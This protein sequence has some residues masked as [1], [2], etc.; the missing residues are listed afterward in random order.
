MTEA[1]DRLRSTD[2]TEDHAPSVSD[3]GSGRQ[4]A[5]T[6]GLV[7]IPLVITAVA[8]AFRHWYPTGDLAQA[9]MRLQSFPANPPLVGAAGR[10]VS[11]AGVQGNHPGP[12]FFWAAYPIYLLL[13][14][15]AWASEASVAALNVA[16]VGVGLWLVRRVAGPAMMLSMAL[17]FAVLLG[18]YGLDAGT[19]LWNPWMALWPFTVLVLATW[20]ALAGHRTLPLAVAA[21]TWAVQAHA[22]YAVVAP[23]LVAFAIVGVAAQLGWARRQGSPGLEP[24]GATGLGRL[25]PGRFGVGL[26]SGAGR[27]LVMWAPPLVDEFTNEPGNLTILWQHF[28]SPDEAVL[29]LREAARITLRLLDPFGQWITGGQFIEGSLIAG[30]GLLIAWAA[31]IVLVCRRGWWDIARLDAAVGVAV[32]VSALSISRAFGVVVLYLFRWVLGLTAL[33]IVAT[34]WPVV[35]ELWARYATADDRLRWSW[36]ADPAELAK[37]VTVGGVVVLV[38]LAGVNTARMVTADIPYE[39]SWSQMAELIDPIVGDLDPDLRYDV[40]WEDPLNLGGLGFGTI[41]ELEHRG[42][43]VGG[44]PQFSAAIEPHR[45]F[46]PGEADAELWVVTGSRTEAWRATPGVTEL[47]AFD[48]RSDAQRAETARLKSE[49]AAELAAVGVDYDPDAPVAMYLFGTAPIPDVTYAKL[50]RLTELG[51]ETAVFEVPPGTLPAP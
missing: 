6:T 29:G 47:V 16:W 22:G 17:A 30:L 8:L 7:V 51:E 48:P 21:A 24:S 9:V 31:S 32:A 49:V 43:D 14:R 39:N 44:P 25:G 23:A 1:S 18:E 27:G 5:V 37:R 2:A 35:R 36:A 19:Q 3:T 15:S 13:G 11:D 33:M 45:V 28:S 40:R 46:Q 12:T 10:I 34:L 42:F 20:A 50:T 38:L 4:V 26:E 41:L